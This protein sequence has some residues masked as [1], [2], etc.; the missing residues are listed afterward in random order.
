M[1]Y[2]IRPISNADRDGVIDI[3]NHYV[4]NS[5]A[6]FPEKKLPYSAFDVFLKMSGGLPTG[7]IKDHSG[8]LIG[9]GMLRMFNPLPA[10]SHTA[11]V[12]YF[13]DSNHTGNGLGKALLSFL[14]DEGRKA[15]ITTILANISSLN[16]G[17]I[18]FHTKNGFKECGRFIAVGK[19]KKQV[20]DTIWMQKM[21]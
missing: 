20:F 2:A 4:E 17:S 11:E 14:E 7:S 21:I 6:A 15:G 5:F 18:K 12:T 19:K 16:P 1:K 3:F 10:F 13:I 9:F 8:Q